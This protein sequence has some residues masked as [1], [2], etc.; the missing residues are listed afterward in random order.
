MGEHATLHGDAVT[1][2]QQ[3]DQTQQRDGALHAVR[4][5]VDADHGIAA[6][7][8]QAVHNGRCDARGIVGR[9]VRLQARGEPA[10]QPHGGA[11]TGN[12]PDLRGDRDQILHAHEFRN[13]RDHLRRQ[14]GRQ[15][16][17]HV[18]GSLIRQ[19]PVAKLADREVRHRREGLGI[20]AVGDQAGDLVGLVR[21][22]E[23]LE[24][25]AQRQ[26]R[27]RHLRGH[28][29]FGGARGNARQIVTGTGGRRLRQ[30]RFEVVKPV[31][32][33]AD[34]MRKSHACP[35]SLTPRRR[36]SE[37]CVQQS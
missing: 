17:Q 23:V 9:M 32:H 21:N 19:Q 11:E 29:L 25:R 14:T 1:G 37:R 8:Q 16:R 18:A 2:P 10:G 7:E 36:N 28:A 33:T 34:G 13:R 20:V 4:R 22:H 26:V 12:D 6:F 27:Q 24:K 5:G 35:L 31:H 30:Q 15:F 3:I